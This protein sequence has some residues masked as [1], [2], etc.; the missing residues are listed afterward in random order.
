MRTKEDILDFNMS[1]DMPFYEA[2][3]RQSKG[4][5]QMDQAGA[6]EATVAALLSDWKEENFELDNFVAANRQS[7]QNYQADHQVPTFNG[8]LNR[9]NALDLTRNVKYEPS[10]CQQMKSSPISPHRSPYHSADSGS[11]YHYNGSPSPSSGSRQTTPTSPYTQALHSPVSP[12]QVSPVSPHGAPINPPLSPHHQ[13]C[14]RSSSISPVPFGGPGAAVNVFGRYTSDNSSMD[15]FG[16]YRNDYGYKQEHSPAD[17]NSDVYK[18]KRARNNIA[19]RRSREKKKQRE[20]QNEIIVQELT[21]EN[22]KLQNKLDVVLKEMKLL[23]SLYKNI[24][25]SLPAE[26]QH[27]IEQELSKLS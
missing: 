20:I 16:Y 6:D 24:G 8:S 26:A 9:P 25:V 7:M 3:N 5:L 10:S 18:L 2:D 17:K 1:Y 19:V 21:E 12:H 22:N 11:V 23:K 27:K 14:S 13:S 4:Q 15:S